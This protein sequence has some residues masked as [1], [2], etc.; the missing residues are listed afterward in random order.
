MYIPGL[1]A[2]EAGRP[3]VMSPMGAIDGGGEVLGAMERGLAGVATAIAE[4]SLARTSK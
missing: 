3:K 2:R 4:K 1:P